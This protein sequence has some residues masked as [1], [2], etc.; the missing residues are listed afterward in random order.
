[1]SSSSS[2]LLAVL[3]LVL[4]VAGRGWAAAAAEVASPGPTQEPTSGPPVSTITGFYQQDIL[5]AEEENFTDLQTLIFEDLYQSYTPFYGAGEGLVDPDD[6][7]SSITTKCEMTSQSIL[8]A[9][10]A[11]GDRFGRN[12]DAPPKLNW[13]LRVIF[14]ITWS[15]RTIVVD[16]YA[17]DFANFVNA[18]LSAVTDDMLASGLRTVTSAQ[19]VFKEAKATP[20]PPTQAPMT[21]PVPTDAPVADDDT[22]SGACLATSSTTGIAVALFV[23]IAWLL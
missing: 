3:A 19:A 23:S 14:R 5:L 17:N 2:R 1:M 16:E 22:S 15:S 4:A 13:K 18:N 7:S 6:P 11:V 9:S 21:P 10:S 12:E 8:G 20:A